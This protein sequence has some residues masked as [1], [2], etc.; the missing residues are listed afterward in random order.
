MKERLLEFLKAEN[1]SSA[2]LAEEIGVQ[3]SGI[4]HILSGRNNPSLDFVLKL[5]ERYPYIS[6]EWFL[7]GKGSMYKDQRMEDLFAGSE[8]ETAEQPL[9]GQKESENSS[10]RPVIP[11]DQALQVNGKVSGNEKGTVLKRIV[12][13]FSDGSFEEYLPAKGSQNL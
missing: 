9:S 3:P 13:F 6:V 12:M 10:P 4:S 1:K 5:L 8:S 7:Y 11:V 2:L